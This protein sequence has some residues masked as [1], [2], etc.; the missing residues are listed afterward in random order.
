MPLQKFV[1]MACEDLVAM[2]G[3]HEAKVHGLQEGMGSLGLM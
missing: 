1:W 2:H 3:L